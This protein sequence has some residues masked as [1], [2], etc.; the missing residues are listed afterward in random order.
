VSS[1]DLDCDPR[2]PFEADLRRYRSRLVA[3]RALRDSAVAV[4]LSLAI[5]AVMMIV[6]APAPR[7]AI[8]TSLLIGMGAVAL[9]TMIAWMQAPSLRRTAVVVDRRLHANDCLVSAVECLRQ[10]DA[11]ADLVVREASRRLAAR[12]PAELLPFELP[13]RFAALL[14]TA[15]VLVLAASF[16]GGRRSGDATSRARIATATTPPT[17]TGSSRGQRTSTGDAQKAPSD[18]VSSSPTDANGPRP[19]RR[20]EANSTTASSTPAD[21]S[22]TTSEPNQGSTG[23]RGSNAPAEHRP[24]NGATS[25]DRGA[26]ASG[27]GRG[28]SAAT[29]SA[30]AAGGVSGGSPLRDSRAASPASAPQPRSDARP[31]AEAAW[32]RAQA[33]IAGN[34]VPGDR[35]QL[36]RD[37]FSALR[38][39][40]R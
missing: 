3:V 6:V 2:G 9:A 7:A 31:G 26:A 30:S 21:A 8:L 4:V 24:A 15:S 1:A 32:T 36:V 19:N 16:V 10:S 5:A 29:R 13:R 14:A 39:T 33:A 22:R 18:A 25:I 23:E 37:Y 38:T 35:R 17:V 20:T 27:G 11:V 40:P 12:R 34:R 28:E